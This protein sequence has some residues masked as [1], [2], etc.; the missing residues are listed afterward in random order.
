MDTDRILDSGGSGASGPPT[1]LRALI[2]QWHWQKFPTF[3]ARF[4]RAAAELA[5]RDGQ[6]GLENLTVSP[7]QFERWYSGTV[8][9]RPYPDACRV[10]EHMFGYTVEQLLAP[11]PDPSK[12]MPAGDLLP[13]RHYVPSALPPA[14]GG[15]GPA[16]TVSAGWADFRAATEWPAWFGMRVAQLVTLV[17]TWPGS[18]SQ[19]D[20]LQALLHQEILMFDAAA[21]EHQDVAY[22]THALSRRQALV[23]LAALPTTLAHPA[24][25]SA[26]TPGA[27]AAAD[28]F[29]SRCAASL[30]A[31]WHLL[32]GSDL[33]TVDRVVPTYLFALE[34]V[35]R[36]E[37]RYQ[38]AAAQL[39]SQ[40]HRILGIIALHRDPLKVRERHCKQALHFAT[41]GSDPNSQ[42]SA[43]ISL[44]STYFYGSNPARAAT[45]YEQALSLGSDLSALQRSRVH[46]EL[47][48]AYGQL[49]REQ[50]AIR[51]A[52]VAEEMYP[53]HPEEDR[54]F[55]YAEFTPASLTLERG[56]AY[57]ALAEQY[58]GRGYQSRASDIFARV[59]QAM[60][61]TVPDRIR[62]EIVNHQ[63]RTAVLQNDLDAFETYMGRGLDGVDLLQSRQ[64]RKEAREAWERA[65]QRWPGDRRLQTVS[66]RL[67][68]EAGHG[69]QEPV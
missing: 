45:V 24:A 69:T 7:R 36:Q 46:A 29:L 6:P 47:A 38:Q 58:P 42:A 66:E 10:L 11:A 68:I 32:R 52:G 1:L 35:A 39:A 57:V 33:S 67:Q 4:R 21:P 56:L 18:I 2:T 49:R 28:S 14:R 19:A 15:L 34:G 62:F 44:A 54:S 30:T 61:A 20:S 8:K 27:A 25:V 43:L 65:R 9:T 63:A 53:G 41:I 55:L 26:G 64:R 60:P 16:R 51:S 23:T 59:E 5:E 22:M 12:P 37:S 48:V 13:R 50:E 3:E 40:A 17:D 31:C